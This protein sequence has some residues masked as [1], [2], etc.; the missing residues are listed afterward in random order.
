MPLPETPRTWVTSE[1]VTAAVMNL[2]VRDQ[3]SYVGD[4]LDALVEAKSLTFPLGDGSAV[5][6]TG[7]HY[8][9]QIPFAL[10]PVSWSL[11]AVDEL[12]GSMVVDVRAE[13]WA[14]GMPGAPDSIAGTEKPTLSSQQKA[15]D[16]SLSSWGVIAA[17]DI[18]GI[19]VESCSTITKA[20]LTLHCH[21]T[22]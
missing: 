14:T 11:V 9:P 6:P 3:F 1:L 15:Q 22:I 17:G 13:D 20:D 5:I 10:T 4:T 19:Y 8:S 7:L 18:L 21:L 16:L 12:T 2:H